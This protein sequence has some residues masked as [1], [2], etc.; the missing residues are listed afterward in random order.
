MTFPKTGLVFTALLLS[1]IPLAYAQ[2]S[3]SA[4]SRPTVGGLRVQFDTSGNLVQPVPE[5]VTKFSQ[6]ETINA[7]APPPAVVTRSATAPQASS[8]VTASAGTTPEANVQS[9]KIVRLNG[10]FHAA[11]RAT[12]DAD[13]KIASDCHIDGNDK[14]DGGRHK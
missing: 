12:I 4:I 8:A 9:G 13:G 7:A 11:S 1:S 10:Y 5:Q 2:N 6:N 3:S 14:K